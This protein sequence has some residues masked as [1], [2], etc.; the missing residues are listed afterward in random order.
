[1]NTALLSYF[2]ANPPACQVKRRAA[3]YKRGGVGYY[4]RVEVGALKSRLIFLIIASA[5]VLGAFALY[6]AAPGPAEAG[7]L[8][9]AAATDLHYISPSLTDNGPAF[10]EVVTDAD[11]K[12]MPRIDGLVRAFAR[13]ICREKP[14]ALILSGDLSFNGARES[15]E[16][17]AGILS[18]IEAG[19]VPVY[20]MPG[21]HD[22]DSA[23]AARFSGEDVELV[24]GVTAGEFAGIYADFGFSEA[25]S[26]DPSSL[27]YTARLA[28]G[29]IL[30][31][32]DVNGGASPGWA[33]DSTL[34]WCEGQLA[35]A[36]ERGERV[37]AVSH[38]NLYSHS[39]LLVNGYM[40]SNA[41]Q[42]EA[43]YEEY[44]VTL[45][46]SGHIH[47][48]HIRSDR[49]VPEI[50]TSSLAVSPNQ[51]GVL[52]IDGVHGSYR[53]ESVDVAAWAAEQGLDEPELTGFEEYSRAFFR[54]T[55]LNQARSELG[56]YEGAGRLADFYA[57]VNAAYFAGR[58][59]LISWDAEIMEE[60][61]S[62]S[63]FTPMYLESIRAGGNADQ[64]R[65][66]W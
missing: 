4:I 43:L 29:L 10:M 49:E 37:L 13:Q 6:D 57:E 16:A 23:M 7:E 58:P 9:I 62:R 24:E 60:W 20:V 22:L 61:S 36:R 65:F 11:G 25:L 1:M 52:D 64:T 47:I 41:A 45:N 55:A 38:Q 5:L 12:V 46:L 39:P 59:D 42:V 8:T 63:F 54:D 15:H 31:M 34:T 2:A 51:Y 27:S 19:G 26:R 30:L 56:D 3:L 35:A 33:S 44:G 17:L 66:A 28:P 48:Q 32:L 21:N 53:T 14:A 18:E 40:I 50:A